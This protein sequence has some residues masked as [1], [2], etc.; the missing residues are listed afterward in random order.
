MGTKRKQTLAGGKGTRTELGHPGHNALEPARS[1]GRGCGQTTPRTTKSGGAD[2]TRTRVPGTTGEPNCERSWGPGPGTHAR[3]RGTGARGGDPPEPHRARVRAGRRGSP[4]RGGEARAPRPGQGRTAR[5]L[6]SAPRF[7]CRFP[8]PARGV[9]PRRPLSPPRTAP[10]GPLELR[11]RP[12]TG[13]L[14]RG[15]RLRSRAPA[16]GTAAERG[17]GRA[18]RGRRAGG[19]PRTRAPPPEP[20][21]Y[22]SGDDDQGR[23]VAAN[24]SEGH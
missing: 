2:W 14:A 4:P 1:D 8:G 19:R 12:A 17:A 21:R 20:L 15:R 5:Y 13:G 18:S 16:S 9:R 7:A 3:A 23:V 22:R 11:S 10:A 24:L 6:D